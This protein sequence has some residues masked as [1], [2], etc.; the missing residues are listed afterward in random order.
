MDV[1][2][3]WAKSKPYPND[4]AS[5]HALWRHLLD[6]AAVCGALLR[7][8]GPVGNLPDIWVMYLAAMHDIGKADPQFQ[9]KDDRLAALL[10]ERGFTLH[11]EKTAF[12]HEARSAEWI[13]PHLAQHSW[14]RHAS[15]VVSEAIC[16]HH[17][18][19]HAADHNDDRFYEED[20]P[21]L[22]ARTAQWR[23]LRTELAGIVRDALGLTDFAAPEFADASA[24]GVQ[25][26]G[27]IVLSDWIASNDE[28]YR[29]DQLATEDNPRAYFTASQQRAT[30]IVHALE[31]DR[32]GPPLE[33]PLQPLQFCDVWPQITTLRP[34]QVAL[35]S[36]CRTGLPPGLAI[37]EAPMGEGKTEAAIYL[38]LHWNR[39]LGREGLYIALPTMATSN[40]MHSRY[41]T[42]LK[43][44]HGI[45][46]R[47]IH[48]MS[49]LRE[50]DTPENE[51]T[52]D[53]DPEEPRR[54]RDWFGNAKR[55]ILAPEGVG[56]VDQVLMAALNVK[57]GFLRFLGLSARTLIIDEVHAYDVYMNVLMRRLL[58]WCRTLRIPVILLSA[59]LSRDQKHSLLKAYGSTPPSEEADPACD[60]YPLLTF[61]PWDTPAFRSPEITQSPIQTQPRTVHLVKHHGLL[62]QREKEAKQ[63]AYR[64]IAKLACELATPGGCIC[65]LLNTVADAQSVYQALGDYP[66]KLLFHARFPA[67]RRGEIET[68][69]LEMFGKGP[70]GNP[71]NPKRPERF[72]LVCTQV[73]EQSLDV[74]FDVMM[75]SLAPIDL[76]L[77]RSGRVWRHERPN[78]PHS[79]PALHLLMPEQG[80]FADPQSSASAFG[81][82]GRVYKRHTALYLTLAELDQREEFR[83]PADFRP[84]IEAC[85]GAHP[86]PSNVAPLLY[87]QAL[88]TSKRD[89]AQDAHA[90]FNH[91][92][93]EPSRREFKLVKMHESVEEG[94]E[95]EAASYFRARTRLGDDS[96]NALFIED[97]SIEQAIKAGVAAKQLGDDRNHAF[98]GYA[99]LRR[100]F[101]QKA[102]FPAWWLNDLEPAPGYEWIREREGPQWTRRHIVF[103]L[104]NREW[105]GRKGTSDVLLRNDPDLGLTFT[106][107]S[108][109]TNLSTQKEDEADADVGFTG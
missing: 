35:E 44:R 84:L 32:V 46:P 95:G 50:S 76:L 37:L 72:I 61:A 36:A 52:T 80:I 31:F 51:V 2:D 87:Q 18:D 53:G 105:R 86:C 103:L 104:Q 85:Y 23:D 34:F 8:F 3:L 9:N 109:N 5:Y 67:E 70:D 68:K 30:K 74:D 16:G 40:Q 1:R 57:H 15:R 102:G 93:A 17:G 27:L 33:S 42:F 77:Q 78:R 43:T 97:H 19:F 49:W 73:V 45:T 106:L 94:E 20:Q 66:H 83:L 6:V 60:A 14:N 22:K 7:R 25:L 89:D 12:R 55:A 59:T 64:R 79:A 54:A 39:L 69:V 10:S 56:T 90:A 65:V 82:T 63:A 81:A 75:T 13:R 100:L 91:L 28:L 48:G 47:L 96:R 26:A 92:I 108:Q 4:S 21:H 58:A 29:Y 71:E 101:L 88:E 98:R 62:P 41:H 107:L 99:V 11:D 24:V 38:A